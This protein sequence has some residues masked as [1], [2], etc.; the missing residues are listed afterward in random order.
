MG[1]T[2]PGFNGFIIGQRWFSHD[3]RI[4]TAGGSKR[5]LQESQSPWVATL[6]IIPEEF[7][8]EKL[9]LQMVADTLVGVIS[10][11]DSDGPFRPPARAPTMTPPP[12]P[13]RF[14]DQPEAVRPAPVPPAITYDLNGV[15]PFRPLTLSTCVWPA[16]DTLSA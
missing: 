3:H 5:K 14:S 11:R 15:R 1:W 6:A 9:D 4:R 12:I 7:G 13:S 16:D 10:R 8:S 2:Q